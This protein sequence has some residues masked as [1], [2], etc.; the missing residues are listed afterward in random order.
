MPY[1]NH[2]PKYSR[3]RPSGQAVV[4]LN[5]KDHYLG[6]YGTAASRH[7]YN[8]IIGEWMAAGRQ[9]PTAAASGITINECLLAYKRHADAY[10]RKPDGTPTSEQTNIRHALK[11]LRQL[12][13]PTP[14]SEFG[15]LKLLA[16]QNAMVKLGWCRNSINKNIHRVRRF[17]K[18]CVSR[19]MLPAAVHHGLVTIT[20]LSAGR[21][22]ARETE[23]VRPAP[24]AHIDA[25]IPH[26][27]AV[28]AAMVRLQLATG[29]RPGEICMMRMADLDM[30]GLVWKYKPQQHKN[31]HR[32]HDRTILLGP[33][34][35]AA[36]KKFIRPSIAG[37]HVFN[38]Q[39]CGG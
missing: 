24:Q 28:V 26:M 13:G 7:E 21:S 31:S 29:A 12:Y 4:R 34:A 11:P 23:P 19:E 36:V 33:R 10:Y 6:A 9:L 25:A 39:G 35:Q 37:Y 18:W 3:H 14:A 5:G 27:P 22:D 8:R 1:E 38:P 20:S 2:I 32:G 17:F 15:P 16:L 30:S